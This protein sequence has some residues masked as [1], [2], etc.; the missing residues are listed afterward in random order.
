MIIPNIESFL[1]NTR[2]ENENEFLYYDKQK[3]LLSYNDTS[4]PAKVTVNLSLYD[5]PEFENIITELVSIP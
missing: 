4:Y 5:Y 1:V 2:T 3:N